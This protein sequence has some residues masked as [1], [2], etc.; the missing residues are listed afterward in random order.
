MKSLLMTNHGALSSKQTHVETGDGGFL[1]IR[2]S[3]LLKALAIWKER[4]EISETAIPSGVA[5]NNCSYCPFVEANRHE[6]WG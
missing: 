5:P 4:A 2:G 6:R 1:P 3:L